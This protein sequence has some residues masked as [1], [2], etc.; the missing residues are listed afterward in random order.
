MGSTSEGMTSVGQAVSK[1]R[2][3]MH[4]S[5]SR[6]LYSRLGARE[7]LRTSSLTDSAPSNSKRPMVAKDKVFEFVFDAFR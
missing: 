6:G 2:A 7:R 3:M 5:T 1:A 4:Q